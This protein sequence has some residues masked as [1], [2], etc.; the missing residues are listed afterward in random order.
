MTP[1]QDRVL[2]VWAACPHLDTVGPPV[3]GPEGSEVLLPRAEH[4]GSEVRALKSE[5]QDC[6]ERISLK[7]RTRDILVGSADI[8]GIS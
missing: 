8:Q 5:P 2:Q 1:E 3:G 4:S 6:W 7:T